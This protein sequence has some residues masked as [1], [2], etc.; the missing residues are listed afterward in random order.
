MAD[1]DQQT[2]INKEESR[3]GAAV[4]G[5]YSYVDA[6]GSLVTVTYSADENGYTEERNVEENFLVIRRR[7]NNNANNVNAV[8]NVAA[9]AADRPAPRPANFVR[10]PAAPAPVAR[11]PAPPAPAPVPVP[12][13]RRP[14]PAQDVDLVA[15]IIAQLTPFIRQTVS[16]SLSENA[17]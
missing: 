10:R 7:D 9:A 1:D 6:L 3:S 2:Y 16:T 12:A 14:A 8:S 13:A 4:T 11:R 17:A 5:K 15:R